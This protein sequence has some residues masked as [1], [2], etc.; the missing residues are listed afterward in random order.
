MRSEATMAANSNVNTILG[1]QSNGQGSVNA[2]RSWHGAALR[3]I[4]IEIRGL[5]MCLGYWQ[6]LVLKRKPVATA[7]ALAT[8]RTSCPRSRHQRHR[9]W[10]SGVVVDP[11]TVGVV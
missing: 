10:M 6:A 5:F 3:A 8:C 1:T 9:R 7:T 4:A 11:G 2:V